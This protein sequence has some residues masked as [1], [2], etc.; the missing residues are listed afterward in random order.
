MSIHEKGGT[1]PIME[2]SII[3]IG[4]KNPSMSDY[5][6]CSERAIKKTAGIKTQI[7]AMGTIVE[8]DSLDKLLDIVKKMH[9]SAMSCGAKR[10]ITN[11]SIDERRD[12]KMNM[13]E[14]VESVAKKI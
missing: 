11:I 3:P 7:T 6:A 5:V 1:M 8:S 13:E 12:K 9:K 4:T 14:E 10:V 2:I